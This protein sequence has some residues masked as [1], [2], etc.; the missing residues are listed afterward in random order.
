MSPFQPTCHRI[1]HDKTT[2][3]ALAAQRAGRFAAHH[4]LS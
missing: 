2:T 1:F 3:V 4:Y